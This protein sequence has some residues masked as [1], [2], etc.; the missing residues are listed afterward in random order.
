MT[1]G[2]EPALRVDN[3]SAFDG[4]RFSATARTPHTVPP[5]YSRRGR[6]DGGAL[7][8]PRRRRYC[9]PMQRLLIALLVAAGPFVTADEGMWTFDNFPAGVVQQKYG[10]RLTDQWLDRLQ[11]SVVRLETGCTASFVSPEGLV[12]TNH[13]CVARA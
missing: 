10:V 9:P 7:P 13:H 8:R 4:D 6:G 11:R 2:P 12:L 1:C 3:Q 5:A